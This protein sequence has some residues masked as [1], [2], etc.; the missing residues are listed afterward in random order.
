MLHIWSCLVFK[1]FCMKCFKKKLFST[2]IDSLAY[3]YSIQE[4]KI[5]IKKKRNIKPTY[6]VR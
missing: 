2:T 5:I 3:L 4:K 6:P 1:R